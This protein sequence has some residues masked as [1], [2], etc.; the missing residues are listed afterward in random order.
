MTATGEMTVRVWVPEVWDAVELAATPEWTIARV[1]DEA[2][3]RATG[4]TPDPERYLVKYKGARMLDEQ[5]TLADLQ[6][7][8]GAP[9][10]VLPARRRPLR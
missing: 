4:R 5:R 8:N 9:F 6:A 1:K 7:R 10:I 2:L 3:R